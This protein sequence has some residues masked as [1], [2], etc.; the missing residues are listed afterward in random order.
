MPRAAPNDNRT[1]M[2]YDAA[3][4]LVTLTDPIATS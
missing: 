2:S 3:R 1:T 4:R